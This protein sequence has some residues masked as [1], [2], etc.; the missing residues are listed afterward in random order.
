M[1]NLKRR[2]QFIELMQEK[3]WDRL[4]LYGHAWR[5]DHFRSLI[6]FSFF[7]THAAAILSR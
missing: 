5:K 7:G 6:N 2:N 3:G 4:L 1:L